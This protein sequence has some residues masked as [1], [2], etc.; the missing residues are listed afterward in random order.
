V[1]LATRAVSL[2]Y[3]SVCEASTVVARNDVLPVAAKQ[4][5]NSIII[6]FSLIIVSLG[7]VDGVPD[8][9]RIHLT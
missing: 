4:A 8:V 5:L 7:S 6:P 9:T 1:K 3:I 2:L